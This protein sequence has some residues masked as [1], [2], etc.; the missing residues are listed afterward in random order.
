MQDAQ[1]RGYILGNK[2]IINLGKVYLLCTDRNLTQDRVSTENV[3]YTLTN[4]SSANYAIRNICAQLFFFV[5]SAIYSLNRRCNDA[6]K[7]CWCEFKLH[8]IVASRSLIK[9]DKCSIYFYH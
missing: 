8:A 7:I 1:K 2:V 4:S 5:T 6:W 3:E 9:D